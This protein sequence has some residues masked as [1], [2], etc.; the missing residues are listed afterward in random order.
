MK[1]PAMRIARTA[2]ADWAASGRRNE[3]A[4]GLQDFV[5]QAWPHLLNDPSAADGDIGPEAS[6]WRFRRATGAAVNRPRPPSR[7]IGRAYMPRRAFLALACGWV[8]AVAIL[9]VAVLVLRWL[10]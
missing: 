3:R 5:G 8:S 6:L 2:E 1:C 10:G 4:V 9:L 7:R